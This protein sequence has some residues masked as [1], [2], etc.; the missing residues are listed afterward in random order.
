MDK[1]ARLYHA[2]LHLYNAAIL[3][4]GVDKD[5]R[6]ELLRKAEDLLEGIEINEAEIKEIEDYKEKIKEQL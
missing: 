4:D 2:A 6:E 3:L 1:N 5:L